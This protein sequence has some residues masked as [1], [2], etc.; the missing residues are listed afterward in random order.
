MYINT[1]T[2]TY[3]NRPKSLNQLFYLSQKFTKKLKANISRLQEVVNKIQSL[4]GLQNDTIFHLLSLPAVSSLSAGPS[5]QTILSQ[6]PMETQRGQ[7]F[8]IQCISLRGNR[9]GRL[10]DTGSAYGKNEGRGKLAKKEEKGRVGG[11]R[12]IP[13]LPPPNISVA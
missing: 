12:S 2:H 13:R 6:Q 1:H 9:F 7:T 11:W 4:E 5:S 8:I 3:R 10:F